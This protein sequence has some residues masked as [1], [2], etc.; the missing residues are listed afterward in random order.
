[1]KTIVVHLS[2]SNWTRQ[3]VHLACALARGSE[4]EVILL[5]LLRVDHIS[6]LGLDIGMPT[7]SRSQYYEML[8]Y[9]GIAESYGVKM[10]MTQMQCVDEMD[11]AAEAVVSLEAEAAFIHVPHSRIPYWRKFLLMRLKHTLA[12]HHCQLFTLDKPEPSNPL[13]TIK[14]RPSPLGK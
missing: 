4:G 14:V 13:P 7:M 6:Y 8:N 12:A 11:A 1:M 10:T 9:S 5:H 3:A 2:E